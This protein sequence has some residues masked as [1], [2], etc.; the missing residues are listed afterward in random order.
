MILNRQ[1]EY[2]FQESKNT[3]CFVCEHV[4][5]KERPILF[6]VHDADDSYWQFLCGKNDHSEKNIRIISIE[7]V[8]KIDSSLNDLWEMPEGICA[9]REKVGAKWILSKTEE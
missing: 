5:K 9:D 7:E 4:M 2:K 1:T 3:A 6:V 8:T